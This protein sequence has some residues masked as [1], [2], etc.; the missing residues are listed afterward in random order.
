MNCFPL[1]FPRNSAGQKKSE[2]SPNYVM[3]MPGHHSLYIVFYLLQIL[4]QPKAGALEILFGYFSDEEL[5]MN[6]FLI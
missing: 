6:Y 2:F 4:E 5:T 3:E 1:L